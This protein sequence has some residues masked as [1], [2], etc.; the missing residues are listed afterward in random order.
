[1]P[2]EDGRLD[3]WSESALEA[4]KLAGE[5]WVRVQ[6]NMSLGAYE[7]FT[8]RGELPEP[9]WP[10]ADLRGLLKVAFRGKVIDSTEHP[11]LRKLRGEV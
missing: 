7:V 10:D 2:G 5:G 9:E 1:M 8:A 4:V 3:S 11:V 6:S